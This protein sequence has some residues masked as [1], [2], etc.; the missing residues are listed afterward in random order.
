M[1]W[2]MLIKEQV[3]WTVEVP[4]AKEWSCLF[5]GMLKSKCFVEIGLLLLIQ[6]I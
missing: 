5:K 2:K 4:Y 1:A 3:G 6:H